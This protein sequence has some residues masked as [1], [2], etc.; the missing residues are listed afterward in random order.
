MAVHPWQL[1][2]DFPDTPERRAVVSIVRAFGALQRQMGPHYGRFGLTP[3][4]FQTITVVN[5]LRGERITQRRLG[6]ELYVSFPNITAIL[7]RLEKLGLIERA[8]NG[9]DR[10]ERLVSITPR[11][12]ALLKL[13]PD[14]KE[15]RLVEGGKG[16][17]TD[18]VVSFDGQWVYYVLLHNLD[19]RDQWSPPKEGADIFKIHLATR[20]VVRLTNQQFTPNTGAAKWSRDFRASES[21]KTHYDYGVFNMGPYPLPGGRLVF[22]SNRDGFRPSKGYPSIALQF[23]RDG[24][25]RYR[26]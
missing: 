6:A 17:V 1:A 24:R 8:I 2:D 19:K 21:G 23:V 14:G 11:G 5:R 7:A 3:S 20:K 15:E 10:R 13:H 22:T 9:E 16:S 18:P 26:S 4:Q 12:R 25:Q